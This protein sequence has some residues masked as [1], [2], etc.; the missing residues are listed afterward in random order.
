[1]RRVYVFSEYSSYVRCMSS[2]H[3]YI[4]C[5]FSVILLCKE[6]ITKHHIFLVFHIFIVLY[7]WTKSCVYVSNL[8]IPAGWFFRMVL[9]F[10]SL[11]AFAF[12][13][14]AAL[15]FAFSA[16]S[17]A[18]LAFSAIRA[19]FS[20]AFFFAFSTLSSFSAAFFA[21]FILGLLLLL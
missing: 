9:F 8:L 11:S 20:S 12:S 15:S 19:C 2:T 6:A 1:M 16:F 13:F 5:A 14:S 7:I 4:L 3:T 17:A 18:L 10:L 21:I